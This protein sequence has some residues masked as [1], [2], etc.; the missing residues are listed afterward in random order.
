MPFF[1]NEPPKRNWLDKPGKNVFYW[2][3]HRSLDSFSMDVRRS[4]G[5]AII[6]NSRCNK[7]PR[8]TWCVNCNALSF[9][10][11]F[12]LS[13]LLRKSCKFIWNIFLYKL[14]VIDLIHAI[15]MLGFR[16]ISY[17]F[18]RFIHEIEHSNGVNWLI[19]Y[20]R[21]TSNRLLDILD[22]CWNWFRESKL[23]LVSNV[24]SWRSLDSSLIWFLS[25]KRRRQ[26]MTKLWR[27]RMKLSS[28]LKQVSG[29]RCRLQVLHALGFWRRWRHWI[30]PQK[31]VHWSKFLDQSL[32]VNFDIWKPSAAPYPQLVRRNKS[33]RRN[34]LPDSSHLENIK[35]RS[36]YFWRP[37]SFRL[38][39]F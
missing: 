11:H 13:I 36:Y 4:W 6:H 21:I 34:T 8:I 10:R 27:S 1:L 16:Y 18:F 25:R 29:F 14:V 33:G 7:R 38:K 35:L 15:I 39:M 17:H 31:R 37:S 22:Q 26:P 28:K 20:L 32:G 3:F 2:F 30:G 19:I 9:S 5:L 24:G 12:L 23:H